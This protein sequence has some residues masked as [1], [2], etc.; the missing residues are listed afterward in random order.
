MTLLTYLYVRTAHHRCLHKRI[1]FFKLTSAKATIFFLDYIV[2]I[3]LP[4]RLHAQQ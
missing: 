2:W 4:S 1:F 3:S